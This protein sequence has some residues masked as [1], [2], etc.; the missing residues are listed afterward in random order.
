LMFGD[1]EIDFPP[2]LRAFK[3][4]GYAGG[5]YV[6]L[7]RHSHEGPSAARRAFEFLAPMMNAS[8]V[9]M[10][11]R[12]RSWQAAGSPLMGADGYML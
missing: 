10:I 5:V 7:S 12:S 9:M 4:V 11:G 2:V 6:E 1:G 3:E 8:K